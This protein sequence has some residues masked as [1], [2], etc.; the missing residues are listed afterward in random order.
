MMQ[1]DEGGGT[2]YSTVDRMGNAFF[3]PVKRK[4]GTTF[5]ALLQIKITALL[6]NEIQ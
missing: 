2:V 1:K 6:A 3:R 4:D 5:G